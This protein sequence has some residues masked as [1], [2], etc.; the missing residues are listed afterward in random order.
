MITGPW[1][2]GAYFAEDARTVTDDGVA[3]VM[4]CFR[5]HFL[6]VSE[7]PHEALLH[8]MSQVLCDE[9]L[10]DPKPVTAIPV[11]TESPVVHLHVQKSGGS[12]LNEML[13]RAYTPTRSRT[14]DETE[15]LRLAKVDPSTPALY[16]GHLNADVLE[17][18]PSGARG[19]VMLRDPVARLRSAYQ[20]YCALDPNGPEGHRLV[21][22]AHAC[23]DLHEF[24]QDPFV[25]ASLETW[26]HQTWVVAGARRWQRWLRALQAQSG[27][28]RV[29]YL[30][31]EVL[32]ELRQSLQGLHFVG[33]FEQFDADA[34]ALLRQLG[35]SHE[36]PVPRLNTLNDARD[37]N[38]R[39]ADQRTDLARGSL[40][41]ALIEEYTMIDAVLYREAISQRHTR[42]A[43]SLGR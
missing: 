41:S 24:L 2:R 18:L 43:G 21:K 14:G 36:G 10:L 19:V 17:R 33:F 1:T 38:S 8:S 39:A 29:V 34:G 13:V 16:F 25:R 22:K 23:A 35:H 32:P 26:N 15:L 9:E 20:Y 11:S 6:S 4:R 12:S 42:H 7:H 3:N 28:D 37:R 40:E 30:E 27:N 5:Q 31:T